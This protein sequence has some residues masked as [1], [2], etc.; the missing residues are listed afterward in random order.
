MRDLNV[1]YIF[2]F[3]NIYTSANG[4]EDTL[5]SAMYRLTRIASVLHRPL[6]QN[7]ETITFHTERLN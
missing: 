4:I 7:L 2:W 3:K 5:T 6:D 1:D